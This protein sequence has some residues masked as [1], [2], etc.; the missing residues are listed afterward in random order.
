MDE[1]QRLFEEWWKTPLG[2]FLIVG[3]GVVFGL[4]LLTALVKLFR[5]RSTPVAEVELTEELGQ[6]PPAPPLAEGA[7]P[8]QCH[9]LKCRI[10]LLVV[11]PLGTDAGSVA[12]EDVIP[13]LESAMPGLGAIA[14]R[15]Q[16]R[17]RL[18]P[19]QLSTQG[20]TAAFRRHAQLPDPE[21]TIKPWILVMGRVLRLRR[22]FALGMALLADR[23]HTLGPIQLDKPHE[24]M[25]VI[26]EGA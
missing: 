10:R 22:P 15:D 24:W 16:P 21:A 8:L 2:P 12:I 4:M 9:G 17:I 3:V 25:E 13:L 26:R 11:A 6:L 1:L 20:F 7:L 19:T 23:D 14:R 5:R 18:W